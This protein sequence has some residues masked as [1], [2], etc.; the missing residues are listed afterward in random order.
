MAKKYGLMYNCDMRI[1]NGMH[2]YVWL[3]FVVW[4]FI[5]CVTVA[6]I[7]IHC[8]HK[9]KSLVTYQIFMPDVDG[10]VVGSPV[11]FMGV[12]VGYIEKIKI[13]REDVYIKIVITDKGVTLPKGSV[14]T[15]EFNGMG[16]SKSLEVYPPTKESLA[17]NKLI[18]V[19][20]PKRLN[21][22]L[23][24]LSQMFDKIGSITT[25]MSFFAEETGIENMNDSINL[26]EIQSNMNIF[27]KIMKEISEIKK[28][29]VSENEQ[30]K[31]QNNK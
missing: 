26:D 21:D 19:E 31:S 2:K 20:N 4:F 17:I 7:K 13:V 15:V 28:K 11:K 12:Q 18:V 6:G 30:S 22:A 1:F 25:R 8:Y 14:A 27:D 29:G 24:L 9:E 10:L 23:G 16:G 5:L 3:E